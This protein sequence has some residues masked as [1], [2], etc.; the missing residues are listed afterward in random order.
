M[1]RIELVKERESDGARSVLARRDLGRQRERVKEREWAGRDL[2][3][4]GLELEVLDSDRLDPRRTCD[5]ASSGL[6]LSVT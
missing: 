3:R 1:P 4:A 2:A 6:T 5:R